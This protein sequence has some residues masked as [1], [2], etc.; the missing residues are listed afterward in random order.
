MCSINEIKKAVI[1]AIDARKAD[2]FAIGESVRQNPELGFREFKTSALAGKVLTS[3]G[4]EVKTGLA[5]TGLRADL[6]SGKE[7][8]TVAVIGEMD[9]L[10]FP[11]HPAAS[12][13]T[14]AV[15]AC[16]HNAHITGMLGAAMGLCDSGCIAALSGKAAFIASPAEESVDM[17]YLQQLL[18]DGKI[19]SATGKAE[20]IRCGVFD[21]VDIAFMIHVTNS[22][23]NHEI[24][25]GNGALKKQ[26]VFHGQSC[27]GAY[28]ERGINA[29]NAMTLALNGIALLR[30]TLSSGDR[31]HGIITSG[32]K[33]VNIIPESAAIEYMLRS[34]TIPRL[35]ELSRTFNKAVSCCAAAIGATVDIKTIPQTMPLTEDTAFY[36][37]YK[38]IVR[39]L[40]PEA[41]ISKMPGAG[42]FG[43]TDMGDVSCIVPVI[44]PYLP[45]SEGTGHS[46]DFKIADFETAYITNAKLLA[47][48]I[49]ELLYGNAEKARKIAEGKSNKLSVTEYLEKLSLLKQ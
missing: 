13:I 37:L 43:S 12:K 29:V 34:D 33:A 17:E 15:H 8:P 35:Q 25:G 27:H 40:L 26:V 28:A 7:G 36:D 30:E 6:E 49:V 16:G 3:L 5:I 1:H 20:L 41:E 10:R 21:D 48:T 31:I 2:L 18:N 42:G 14:G 11:E 24:Y 44:H 45:C 22:S 4:M 47:L 23:N 32:G 46:V 19:G 39:E 9:A 38:N